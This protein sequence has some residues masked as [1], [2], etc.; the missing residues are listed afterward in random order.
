[1]RFAEMIQT[2]SS[3]WRLDEIVRIKRHLRHFQTVLTW[4]LGIA[5]I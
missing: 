4:C 2:D 3:P 1:M 5:L